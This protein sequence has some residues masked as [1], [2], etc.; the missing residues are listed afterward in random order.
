[1]TEMQTD[2]APA[3]TD[4]QTEDG[5]S[6]AVDNSTLPEPTS[7]TEIPVTESAGEVR[8]EVGFNDAPSESVEDR[9]TQH[10]NVPTSTSINVDSPN[11]ATSTCPTAM[12]TSHSSSAVFTSVP[13]SIRTSSSLP[14]SVSQDFT[15]LL[16]STLTVTDQ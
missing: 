3:T 1:M 11:V 16:K 9:T 2:T 7:T 8:S 12:S 10:N 6:V 5:D 15:V 14:A 4:T 13:T